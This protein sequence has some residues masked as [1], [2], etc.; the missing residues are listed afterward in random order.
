MNQENYSANLMRLMGQ[1]LMLPLT[2]F[3]YGFEAM[4]NAMQGL[5]TVTNQ[6]MGFPTAPRPQP[7]SP[8]GLRAVPEPKPQELM[9]NQ[10]K[11]GSRRITNEEEHPLNENTNFCKPTDGGKCLVLWRYKVL[12]I[13]R[14]LEHAF[15]EEEDLVPDD[16]QDITAWKIAEFIQRLSQRE[17]RVPSSWVN[18]RKGPLEYWRIGDDD[19]SPASYDA[20]Q[21]AAKA[22]DDI[23]LIGLPEDDKRHLRLFSQ[24]LARYT[25]EK[26]TYEEDQI[27]VLEQIRDNLAVKNQREPVREGPRTP[28]KP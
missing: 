14:D 8:L 2:V 10:V 4:A 6:N 9:P 28:A 17:V 19:D 27:R 12:F 25:R 1:F 16:V 20:A 22:G 5:Q 21:R 13:K 7:F 23:W 18:K 11:I 26:A 24:E 15:A 3:K